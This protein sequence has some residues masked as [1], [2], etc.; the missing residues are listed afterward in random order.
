MNDIVVKHY[1]GAL[2]AK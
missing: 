1:P 2:P